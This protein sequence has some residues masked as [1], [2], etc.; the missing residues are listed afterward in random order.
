MSR[1]KRELNRQRLNEF[2]MSSVPTMEATKQRRHKKVHGKSSPRQRDRRKRRKNGRS[3]RHANDQYSDFGDDPD[4]IEQSNTAAILL[5]SDDEYLEPSPL[6]NRRYQRT[7]KISDGENN[8][9]Q[10]NSYWQEF[11]EETEASVSQRHELVGTVSYTHL[12]LPTKA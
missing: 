7:N 1:M 10:E 9:Q 12:T 6:N 5:G 3:R 2:K 8:A 4:Y 11:E